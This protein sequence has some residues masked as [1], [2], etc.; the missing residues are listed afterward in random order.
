MNVSHSAPLGVNAW[1]CLGGMGILGDSKGIAP[2][3]NTFYCKR[4]S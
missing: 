3:A 4:L 1:L 2:E